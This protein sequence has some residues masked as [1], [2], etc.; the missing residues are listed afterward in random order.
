DGAQ[1][2]FA[3]VPPRRVRAGPGPARD[4]AAQP[5]LPARR[6]LSATAGD[7]GGRPRRRGWDNG[8]MDNALPLGREVAYPRAYDPA[9][10]FPID[11]AQGRSALGLAAGAPPFAGHDRWHAYELSW[12][13]A[14]GKPAVDTATFLVPADSP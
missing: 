12:L 2:P 4:A 8:A 7:G 10:L 9:L 11:R 5:R 14:R 6:G 13:D 1:Q 3:R